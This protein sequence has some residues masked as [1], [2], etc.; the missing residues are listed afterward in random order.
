[1]AITIDQHGARLTAQ[2]TVSHLAGYEFTLV[3]GVP[4]GEDFVYTKPADRPSMPFEIE[5]DPSALCGG[6]LV[7]VVAWGALTAQD[8]SAE[9]RIR[10]EVSQGDAVVYAPN[11]DPVTE[12]GGTK[13]FHDNIECS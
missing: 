4:G 5:R 3:A 6:T 1:M 13:I 10:I 11:P 2:V 7:I 12:P 9:R 8:A